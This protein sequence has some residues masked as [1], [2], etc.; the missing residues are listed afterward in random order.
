MGKNIGII[1]SGEVGQTLAG[2]FIKFGYNVCI[3][4][5]KPSKLADWQNQ[6]GDKGSTGTFEEAAK[7]GDIVVLCVKGTAAIDA[8]KLAGPQNLKQKTV[9]D[10]TNPIADIPPENGVLQFFTDTNSS[11]IASL[12][13]DF[14]DI[15]FVKA[16]NSV[17][18]SFMVNPD[19]D[20][21][22]P[23]MFI[24]GNHDGSK[25]NVKE[26]LDQFGWQVE[27]MGGIEAGGPI[28]SLCRLWCIPGF[29]ENRWTHAFKLLK[30]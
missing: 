19:F 14:P 26:I 7:F 30:I 6:V 12:Q 18:S 16:F 28:E 9:I 17:G 3:G 15:H 23:S 20:G 1:G 29:R 24:C 27:D 10:T 22:Q 8:L 4:S 11:L 2:G 13:N 5:R 21:Q 25:Q